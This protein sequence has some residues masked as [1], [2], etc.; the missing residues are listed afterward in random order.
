MLHQLVHRGAHAVEQVRG[1]ARGRLGS[2]R[3][4]QRDRVG[5]GGVLFTGGGAPGVA[6]A[7][8]KLHIQVQPG[9]GGAACADSGPLDL[10]QHEQ[11]RS[12]VTGLR[13]EHRDRMA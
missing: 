2:V 5:V 1:R 13:A 9:E 7:A 6:G 10:L 4:A 3:V 12:E 8:T 11:L